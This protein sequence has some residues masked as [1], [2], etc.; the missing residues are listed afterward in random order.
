VLELDRSLRGWADVVERETNTDCRAA[1]GAGAAGGV[2]FAALAVLGARMQP[3]IDVI[4]DRIELDGHLQGACAVVTGEGSLDRQSLRGKAAV[5][6]CRRASAYGVPTFAVAGVSALTAAEARAAGFAGVYALSD[7]EPDRE[8]SMSQA[9][10]LLAVA[11]EQLARRLSP[12]GSDA[13]VGEPADD[14]KQLHAEVSR[15]TRRAQRSLTTTLPFAV[16]SS[17]EAIASAARS[18]R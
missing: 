3:G 14:R 2:G 11:T 6:V 13:G 10:E 1:A 15:R 16:R 18:I 17:S 9:A 8:R 5:G 7:L 4:L 12:L